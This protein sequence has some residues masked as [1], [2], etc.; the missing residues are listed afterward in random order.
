MTKNETPE[1]RKARFRA[2]SSDE[3]K[4][5]I[6]KKLKAQGLREGS[7]VLGKDLSSYNKEEIIDLILITKCVSKNK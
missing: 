1:E 5:L 6:K 2:L 3:R 4:S 7:G